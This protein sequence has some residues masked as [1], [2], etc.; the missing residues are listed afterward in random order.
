MHGIS[1]IDDKEIHD[2]GYTNQTTH[3]DICKLFRLAFTWQ[4]KNASNHA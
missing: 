3:A 2:A 4:L 1:V